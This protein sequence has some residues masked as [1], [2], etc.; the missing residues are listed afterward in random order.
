[1]AGI[2]Q[3]IRST[4]GGQ[5]EQH[6][7]SYDLLTILF[8]VLAILISFMQLVF[9]LAA[10]FLFLALLIAVVLVILA[11]FTTGGG[12]AGGPIA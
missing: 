5:V 9:L 2:S 8:A 11:L 1:M 12:A 3:R 7:S 10:A 6:G 4:K